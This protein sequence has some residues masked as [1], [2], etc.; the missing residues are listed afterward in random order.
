MHDN[1]ITAEGISKRLENAYKIRMTNSHLSTEQALT[2]YQEAVDIKDTTLELRA[3]NTIC[4]AALYNTDFTEH[5]Q[6]IDLLQQ[7]SIEL[8]NPAYTGVSYILR[9]RWSSNSGKLTEA[10][11]FL[12]KALDYLDPKLNLQ[13]VA[14]CYNSL[15]KIYFK[16]KN[17][18]KA[19]EYLMK[20]KP[21]ADDLPIGF[22]FNLQQ[23][24]G[25][26]HIV[27]KEY[28]EAWNIFHDLLPKIPKS[29][30]IIKTIVLQNLGHICQITDELPD[31]LNY[32]QEARDLKLQA[33]INHELIRTICNIVYIY[34][35]SENADKA[36]ENLQIANNIIPECKL[37]DKIY[38]Y[39]AFIRY[40]KYIND[41]ANQVAY[42][43][44]LIA[45]KDMLAERDN[46]KKV[47]KLEAQHQINL[48]KEKSLML[49]KKNNHIAGQ[50]K[51]LQATMEKLIKKD[52]DLEIEMRNAFNTINKKDDLLAA[53]H[54][55]ASVG[56]MIAIIAHQWKQ[57]LSIINSM[58]FS[59]KDAYHYNELSEDFINEKAK[60]IDDLI[61]YLSQTMNDFRNFFKKQNNV[62]FKVCCCKRCCITAGICS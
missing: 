48:Y 20:A 54:R 47:D 43:E 17:Y 37:I 6:W 58:V 46:L 50:N 8:D 5:E 9:S 29:E 1:S 13:N 3:I 16:N 33:G 18:D 42:Y 36:Y 61:Q 2:A 14:T 60:M 19:Y 53:H 51:K 56:E 45:A 49:E 52:K 57:P 12:L 34:L 40:Y 23:N 22:Y 7:R 62:D 38:L 31:A 44:K 21:F 27:R 32:F 24:I 4:T 10:A 59:I 30:L 28:T 35:D 11:G 39:K 55:L 41:L 26:I 15:G 25:A